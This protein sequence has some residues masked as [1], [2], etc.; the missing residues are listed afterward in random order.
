MH[1]SVQPGRVLSKPKKTADAAQPLK[2]LKFKVEKLKVIFKFQRA[3]LKARDNGRI[4]SSVKGRS[5]QKT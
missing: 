3:E 5:R 1:V 2:P 4:L